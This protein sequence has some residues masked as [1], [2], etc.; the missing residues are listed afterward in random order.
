M[1]ELID[2]EE[3]TLMGMTNHGTTTTYVDEDF[4]PNASYV[5]NEEEYENQGFQYSLQENL[6]AI[7]PF[8]DSLLSVIDNENIISIKD[9][10]T[11][12]G[13]GPYVKYEF[14]EKELDGDMYINGSPPQLPPFVEVKGSSTNCTTGESF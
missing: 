10:R 2:I 5:N 4:D 7:N 8:N 1:L 12:G 9:G 3:M 14:I 6:D 13:E 11:I